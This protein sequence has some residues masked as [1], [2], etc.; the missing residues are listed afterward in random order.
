M[1]KED[2]LLIIDMQEWFLRD[3]PLR[4]KRV[5]NNCAREIR[6]AMR[7]NKQIIFVEYD[8]SGPTIQELKDLV[9]EYP[10]VLTIYKDMDDGSSYISR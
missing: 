5:R 3:I 7:L 2:C 8:E 1:P 4:G 6:R 9:K 10:N